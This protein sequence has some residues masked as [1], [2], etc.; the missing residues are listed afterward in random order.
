MSGRRFGVRPLRRRNEG[1]WRSRD[2]RLTFLRH[3]S[4]P[5][6]QRW[7]VYLDD[8]VTP[9]NEGEGHVRLQD[10]ADWA[11]CLN[12]EAAEEGKAVLV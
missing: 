12:A 2:E 1:C 6:P 8:D 7:F 9:L 3:W 4:D 10:L 11:E 5:S